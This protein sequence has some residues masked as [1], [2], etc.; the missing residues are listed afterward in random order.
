MTGN[1]DRRADRRRRREPHHGSP[2][3]FARAE[4]LALIVVAL[5]GAVGVLAFAIVQQLRGILS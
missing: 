2:E 5:A 3:H 4:A 1:P